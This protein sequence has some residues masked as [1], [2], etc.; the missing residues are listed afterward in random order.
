MVHEVSDREP[1][2]SGTLAEG[3]WDGA[4]SAALDPMVI[5]DDGQRIVDANRAACELLGYSAEELTGHHLAD[6]LAPRQ[7]HRIDRAWTRFMLAGEGRGE[8]LLLTRDG[9]LVEVEASAAANISA[10]RHLFVIRDVSERKRADAETRRR[11]DQQ[12]V[13]AELG[14]IALDGAGARQLMQHAS[15]G[16]ARVLEVELVA[17]LEFENKDQDRLISAG[18]GWDE[19]VVGAARVPARLGLGAHALKSR[20]PVVVPDISTENRFEIP[21]LLREHGVVS[22]AAVAIEAGDRQFGV[23]G[24]HSRQRHEFSADDVH[25]LQTVANVLGAAVAREGMRRIEHELEQSRRLESIGQLAGGV[26]HD[27]N[28]LLG[29]IT[30]YSSFALKEL[31]PASQVHRDISEVATAAA[32]G[33]E[34]TK[35]L[36]LFSSRQNVEAQTVDPNEMIRG[37]SAILRRTIGDHIELHSLL[38]RDAPAVR[39]GH[40]QLEQ[41]LMNLAVNARDAMPNGGD[42]TIQTAKIELDEEAEQEADAL[43]AGPYF[44]LSVTD[45]GTGMS[46]EVASQALEPFFTTKERSKGTGLGLATVYGIVQA[47][48]GRV[49]IESEQ[50]RGTTMHVYLPPSGEVASSDVAA[51]PSQLQGYG[52]RVLLV[53]D[54]AMVR[55]ATE[56]IL[57]NNGYHVTHFAD[58]E[59]ALKAS[60]DAGDFDI[61]VTDV[62]M[63]K[64]WGSELAERIRSRKPRIAVVYISG[65]AEASLPT[66]IELGET[67]RLIEKPYTDSALLAG[68]RSAIES[69][70]RASQNG[71][72][73]E[74]QA[75]TALRG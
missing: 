61:L 46:E 4:F 35:Q 71:S 57:A 47:A 49:R 62:L 21:P 23:L 16:V 18:V 34:L 42:L 27:F 66:E 56:R 69:A 64:M 10:G 15:E 44:R 41:V 53:E 48:R 32:H 29:V 40:G 3:R 2:G 43:P 22:A 28:N 30:S 26:A 72:G 19:G 31:D 17:V 9:S 73:P 11:G 65:L 13:V 39:L 37:T 68:V 20:K 60:D 75:R 55:R 70:P 36:L 33:A 51:R 5:L 54:D 67:D 6:V 74:V 1:G 24:A 7:R 50:G 12:A 52:E 14:R 25:F 58:G 45:T 38:S 63:P 8:W 59:E